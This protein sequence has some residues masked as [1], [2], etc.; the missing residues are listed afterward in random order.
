MNHAS[1][2][3][4][5]RGVYLIT[6]DEPD[7][8]RLLA[9]T[10]PLLA[11]G[12]TLLQYRN[13]TADAPLRRAQAEALQALCARYATPLIINDDPALAQAVGAAGVHLGEDDEGIAA[14]RALLG[15]T[16]IIGISCYDDHARAERAATAGASYLAFGAFFASNSKA[17]TRRATPALLRQSAALGLPRVAIG[18]L[19]PD[20]V[21]PLIA[22]GADLIAVISSVYAAPDPVA[23]LH[24]YLDCFQEPA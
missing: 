18:G 5:P 1:A 6:P 11:T 22:A 4:P 24:A 12:V 10:A 23:T 17:T 16:A 13:K 19:T 15:P 21:A 7:T 8:A 3:T 9:R 20:N 14:A 2:P